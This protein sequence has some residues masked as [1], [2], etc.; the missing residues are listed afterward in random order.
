MVK[1]F[2]AKILKLYLISDKTSFYKKK[3]LDLSV[4]N[5]SNQKSFFFY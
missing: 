3:T 5:L 4:I 1:F 2:N